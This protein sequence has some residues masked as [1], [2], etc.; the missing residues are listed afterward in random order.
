MASG[1][2]TNDVRRASRELEGMRGALRKWL[3]YRAINDKAGAVG[4]NW[5]IEQD[6]A[7]KL[8]ALLA[9]MFPGAPLPSSDLRSN[10]LGA[11]QLAAIAITGVVPKAPAVGA[12]AMSGIGSTHPWLWPV[13]IVGGLLI[14]VTTA[15]KSAADVAAQSE[16]DQCIQSGA[17]TDYG[18]W[19]KAGG[20]AMLAYVVWNSLGGRD[21]VRGLLGKGGR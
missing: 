12:P 14:A 7:N 10:P 8:S 4:R 13:L 1:I 20:I 18:F 17:C 16:H 19:L 9:T 11:V 21:A 15:I 2:S 5:Q 3:K 6:L